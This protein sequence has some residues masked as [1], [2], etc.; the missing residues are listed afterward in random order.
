MHGRVEP[1]GP[2]LEAERREDSLGELAAGRLDSGRSRNGA[3]TARRLLDELLED[4]LDRVEDLGDLGR[5]NERLEVVEKRRVRRVV[6]LEALDVAA[7]QLEVLLER[8]EEASKSFRV[9]ASTQMW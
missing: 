1:P 2:L 5:L 7:L 9:R 6:P 3:S 4:G 8:G